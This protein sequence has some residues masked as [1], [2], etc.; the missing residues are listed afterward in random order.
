GGAPP[1]C[2]AAS[3][4]SITRMR[5]FGLLLFVELFVLL[6]P[7]VLAFVLGLVVFDCWPSTVR[8]PLTVKP[9]ER[10]NETFWTSEAPT[11]SG[12]LADMRLFRSF[13]TA[14]ISYEP[15]TTPRIS[16]PP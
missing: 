15:G 6:F 7:L 11:S 4:R 1:I 5:V 8:R 2:T 16:N 9:G 14:T 10:I 12:K 3:G 13:M